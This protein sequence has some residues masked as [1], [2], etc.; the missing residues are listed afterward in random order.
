MVGLDYFSK[1]HQK[2]FSTVPDSFSSQAFRNILNTEGLKTRG[3]IR[4]TNQPNNIYKMTTTNHNQ[5]YSE[6]LDHVQVIAVKLR[7]Y[8]Q[9]IDDHEIQTNKI[10]DLNEEVYNLKAVNKTLLYEVK[11]LRL[12]LKQI[13]H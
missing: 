2:N 3:R 13:N 12:K 6:I 4:T 10:K 5:N 9:L 1:I 11:E 8:S 7:A